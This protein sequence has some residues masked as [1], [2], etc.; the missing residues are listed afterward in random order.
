MIKVNIWL[1]EEYYN[2]LK[3]QAII[4]GKSRSAIV[5]KL[6][7]DYLKKKSKTTSTESTSKTD[8]NW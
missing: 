1:P 6:L 7:N 8:L 3:R 4:D 5:R 2:A